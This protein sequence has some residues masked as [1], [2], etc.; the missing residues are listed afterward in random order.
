MK[1]VSRSTRSA[2]LASVFCLSILTVIAIAL[3]QP[4][5]GQ[6]NAGAPPPIPDTT[7]VVEVAD[8]SGDST[9]MVVL[10]GNDLFSVGAGS[11]VGAL[12]RADQLSER[13]LEVAKSMRQRPEDLRVLEDDRIQA[14]LLMSGNV[15]LGVVWDY[16]AEAM[17]M[18]SNE[19]AAQRIEIIRQAVID[20]RQDFSTRAII[21]GAIFATL[22]ITVLVL[23]L[24]IIS[25]LRRRL[26]G[27]LERKLSGRTML[28]VLTGEGLVAFASAVT[29][30]VNLVFNIWLILAA[31]NFVLSFFPW[32]YSIASQVF[33]L[34]AGPVRTF[35]AAFVQQI[36]SLFFLAFIIVATIYILRGVRFFFNEIEKRRI[37]IRGFYSDWAHPTFNIVRMVIFAFAVVVAFPYIPG[38]SSGAFKGMSLFL[39]VLISLGSSSAMANIV[40]GIILIYMRPFAVGDRVQIGDTIG[41]VVDRNLLTTRI[42]STKNERVT[43]PNTNILAGQ[44]INFTSKRRRKELILH[45]SVTIGYDAPW[46]TV[47]ALLIAAAE[48]TENVVAEPAPFVLQKGLHDFY[49]EYELN[50]HTAEP[51]L[52]P[53][54]Y[55]ELHQNIQDQFNNAGVEILSPHFRALRNDDQP[56]QRQ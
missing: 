36:P 32:T 46:R 56:G 8:I 39:G 22:T 13:I 4:C 47:H 2:A 37:T 19:L 55:S 41:D 49:I 25:R 6:D 33:E 20:Y 23:I 43:I 34:A 5:L 3:A 45:T 11:V 54:T 51:R 48:A 1:C 44:I 10:L 52:I 28:K 38:S 42:R 35:G 21:K 17:G 24:T 18:T 14:N 31:L 50:A 9:S 12:A 15:L 29:R 53:A 7:L 26:D 30:L 16:E 40:S 27:Y